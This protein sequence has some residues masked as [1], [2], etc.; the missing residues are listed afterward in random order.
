MNR[1]PPI[2]FCVCHLSCPITPAPEV[3]PVKQDWGE[4]TLYMKTGC[5]A[6]NGSRFM[7]HDPRDPRPIATMPTRT[8]HMVLN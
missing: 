5:R 1:G 7:T 8:L 4:G 2:Q 6:H 3:P